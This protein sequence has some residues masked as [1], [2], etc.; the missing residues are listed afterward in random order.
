VTEPSEIRAGDRV[1]LRGSDPPK[2]GKVIGWLNRSAD[3]R[4]DKPSAGDPGSVPD[5]LASVKWEG[6]AK[7]VPQRPADLEKLTEDG[8][9]PSGQQVNRPGGRHTHEDHPMIAVTVTASSP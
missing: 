4:A 2:V 7:G 8:P 1:T 3:F 9:K 6:Q 5:V